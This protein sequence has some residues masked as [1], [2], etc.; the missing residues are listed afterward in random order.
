[1]KKFYT[2]ALFLGTIL[3]ISAQETLWQRDIRSSTQDFLSQVTTTIDGQYLISGS[4]IRPD[5]ISSDSQQNNGYD[6]HLV[7]LNQQGEQTWEKFFA[8]EKS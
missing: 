4:S 3:S 2:G 6:F 5:K 7:K 1:M 8:G